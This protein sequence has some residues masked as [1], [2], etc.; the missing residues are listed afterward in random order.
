MLTHEL[1]FIQVIHYLLGT[2][3]LS[4]N[5][6][7]LQGKYPLAEVIK[8]VFSVIKLV[9]IVKKTFATTSIFGNGGFDGASNGT[10]TQLKKTGW[11]EVFIDVFLIG[12]WFMCECISA[13]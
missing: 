4:L 8:E 10:S 3:Q 2:K 6:I 7:T 1:S 9:E 11:L 5:S 12:V 13:F